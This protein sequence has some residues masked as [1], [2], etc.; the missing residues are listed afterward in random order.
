MAVLGAATGA[1]GAIH[2]GRAK[3]EIAAQ[4]ARMAEYNASLATSSAAEEERR[5]RVIATKQ[6][7]EMRANFGASGVSLEGSPLDVLEESAKTAELDALT[8][9]HRGALAAWGFQQ[10]AR[11]HTFEERA[12][13][14]TGG[15]NAAAS[16][17]KGGASAFAS[18]GGGGGASSSSAAAA[19]GGK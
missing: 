19:G 15:I 9:R 6:I 5:A 2:E 18:G 13:H 3:G 12:A 1:M 14:V 4:Q 10:E 7:G 11:M 17:F 16:L 8:I